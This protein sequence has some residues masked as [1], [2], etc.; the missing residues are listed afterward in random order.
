M[1]GMLPMQG[2]LARCD[3]LVELLPVMRDMDE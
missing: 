2:P 3:C 1:E